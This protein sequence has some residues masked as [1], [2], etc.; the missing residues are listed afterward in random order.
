MRTPKTENQLVKMFNNLADKHRKLQSSLD[1][2]SDQ[3]LFIFIIGKTYEYGRSLEASIRNAK[4]HM[5]D[6]NR[7]LTIFSRKF[8]DNITA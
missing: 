1:N 3:E 6:K 7:A 8:E 5:K 2:L 4:C